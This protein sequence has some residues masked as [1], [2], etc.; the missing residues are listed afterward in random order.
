[1]KTARAESSVAG[2]ETGL[3]QHVSLGTG[4]E[5]TSEDEGC[6]SKA[7]ADISNHSE[8]EGGSKQAPDQHRRRKVD[9]RS[10]HD[11]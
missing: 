9:Y 11:R 1:M 3:H 10:S 7:V 6:N 4:I 5:N 8:G 2:C